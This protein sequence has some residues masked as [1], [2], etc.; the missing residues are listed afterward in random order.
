MPP[1]W[2]RASAPVA[3]FAVVLWTGVARRAHAQ[4]PLAGGLAGSWVEANALAQQVTNNFGDW[5]GVYVRAVR[6]GVRNTWY[7]DVLTL[8]AF[9]ERGAQIGVTQRHDWNSRLFQMVGVSIGNG[10]AIMP[11]F[12]VDGA[13][14]VRLGEARR[15]QATGGVSYVKS[16]TDLSDIAG[17]ASLGW[18]APRAFYVEVNGRYN[19]ARPGN[20]RS[21]R[22]GL[23]SIYTPNAKR[24]F[25]LRAIGGTEGWQTV[26]AGTT[27][28]R[29]HSNEV[30]LAWRE[31]LTARIALSIQGDR[32]ENPF[33]VRQ[34]VTVGVARYW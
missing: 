13:L 33:Y 25:S 20:I 22:V 27:L 31:R 5:R 30:A 19:T 26:R 11:R 12:R 23:T 16:V 9:R 17:T 32:Y 34:G 2:R 24:S 6:P 3:L 4:A 1:D 29:F 18:Y 28:T 7:G 14:G 15:W 8:D 10:A 21:H